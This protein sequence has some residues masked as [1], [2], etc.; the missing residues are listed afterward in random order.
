MDVMSYAKKKKVVTFVHRGSKDTAFLTAIDGVKNLG[1]KGDNWIFRVNK[2]LGKKSFAIT[3][4]KMG[5]SVTW[6][7]GKY[8][9]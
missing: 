7:F 1:A 5:D 3:K 8:K 9:P 6:T 4:L 2:K